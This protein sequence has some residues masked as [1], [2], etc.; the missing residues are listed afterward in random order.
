MFLPLA[1]SASRSPSDS[2]F[3]CLHHKL[4]STQAHLPFTTISLCVKCTCASQKPLHTNKNKEGPD[5]EK[6][7]AFVLGSTGG[8][9][10]RVRLAEVK[11]TE[12]SP[13]PDSSRCRVTQADSWGVGPDKGAHFEGQDSVT[14]A[15]GTGVLW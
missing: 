10:S 11:G 15:P 8:E 3:L 6:G 13:P 7:P 1:V 4:A 2:L 5:K 12:A 14:V 9:G